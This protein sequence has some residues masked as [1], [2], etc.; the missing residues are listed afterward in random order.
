MQYV[1]ITGR[2][3]DDA[4]LYKMENGI[5]RVVMDVAV[6]DRNGEKETTTYYHVNYIKN[7]WYERLKKGCKV[8]LIGRLAV[9]Q[10]EYNGEK[11]INLK[12]YASSLEV[13]SD[14]P[15]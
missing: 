3:V 12:V 15:E 8:Q 2:L 4:K 6:N 7:G 10:T 9:E 1:M 11:R 5:E 13:A 14:K